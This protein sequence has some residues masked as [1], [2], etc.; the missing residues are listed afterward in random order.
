MNAAIRCAIGVWI[1][2]W[3]PLPALAAGPVTFGLK[4][5]IAVAD[6]T[7]RDIG[8]VAELERKLGPGGGAF[9]TWELSDRFSLGGE[10]LYVSKGLSYGETDATDDTGTN[11]GT[12]ETLRV[13]DYVEIPLLLRAGWPAGGSVRPALVLGPAIAFKVRE[14]QTTT[15][16]LTESFKTDGFA[17]TDVGLATGA[18]VRFRTGPGWSLIEARYTLGLV[19]V[20][21]DFSGRE[22]KN[23]AL[24]VMAG[25]A[26]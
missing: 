16:V 6:V 23:R 19:N 21:D 8:G 25:Y 22:A 12:L 3:I 5:G 26:F 20:A 13:I 10:I 9:A 1:A 24:T 2:L 17:S 15:G 11:I 4:A 14:R 18:E 7:P